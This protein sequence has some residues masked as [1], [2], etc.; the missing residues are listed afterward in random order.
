MKPIKDKNIEQ[1]TLLLSRKLNLQWSEKTPRGNLCFATN[2]QDLRDEFKQVLTSS[3]VMYYL[4][5]WSNKQYTEINQLDLKTVP[6]PDNAS[7]F[8]SLVNKGKELSR[9]IS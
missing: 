5:G 4:M 6:L 7:S 1:L 2:N 3:D 8:W 9:H